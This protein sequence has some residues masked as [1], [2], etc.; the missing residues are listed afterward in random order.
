MC[1]SDIGT[2]VGSGTSVDIY[3]Q[4]NARGGMSTEQLIEMMVELVAELIAPTILFTTLYLPIPYFFYYLT[5]SGVGNAKTFRER[6]IAVLERALVLSPVYPLF[7]AVLFLGKGDLMIYRFIT[8]APIAQ[9]L[10]WAWL[11]SPLAPRFF[12]GIG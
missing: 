2:Y 11:S 5:G 8:L 10:L 4:T 6:F 12:C 1:D 7:S 3:D 9:I